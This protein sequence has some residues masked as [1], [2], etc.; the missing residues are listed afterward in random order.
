MEI[1]VIAA[2]ATKWKVTLVQLVQQNGKLRN[3]SWCNKMESYVIPAGATKW[4][5]TLFQ[6]MK[7]N[8]K[9]RY[10]SLC[11]KWKVTLFQLVQQSIKDTPH[12][13]FHISSKSNVF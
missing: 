12:I 1:C 11:N 7:Q 5:V 4:K 6:L 13:W 3:S 10:S 9:L 2:C 8:G